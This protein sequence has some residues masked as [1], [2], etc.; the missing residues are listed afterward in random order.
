MRVDID[1]EASGLINYLIKDPYPKSVWCIVARDIDTGDIYKFIPSYIYYAEENKDKVE[2]C[3]KLDYFK[4]W[5]KQIT[6]YWG[7]N[8]MSYDRRV[9]NALL[10]TDITSAQVHDTL[11]MSKMLTVNRSAGH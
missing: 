1:I 2:E 6:E 9:L 11:I 5:S 10:G 4:E 7:H 3:F 8:F